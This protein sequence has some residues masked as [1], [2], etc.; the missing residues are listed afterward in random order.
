MSDNDDDDDDN[1]DKGKG[2]G[3]SAADDEAQVKKALAESGMAD[4]LSSELVVL[5]RRFS[6]GSNG[7]DLNDKASK[8]DMESHISDGAGFVVLVIGVN[9]TL[10]CRCRR[11]LALKKRSKRFYQVEVLF[12]DDTS[13]VRIALV[14]NKLTLRSSDNDSVMRPQALLNS[15][16]SSTSN[17]YTAYA[18]G[19]S[20]SSTRPSIILRSA[21]YAHVF[22]EGPAEEQKLQEVHHCL[23]AM[24]GTLTDDL[25]S[26]VLNPGWN[27][28]TGVLSVGPWEFRIAEDVG[29]GAADVTDSEARKSELMALVTR[30]AWDDPASRNDPLGNLGTHGQRA[31]GEHA[32]PGWLARARETAVQAHQVALRKEPLRNKLRKVRSEHQEVGWGVGV[33]VVTG[34]GTKSRSGEE[35]DTSFFASS[36]QSVPAPAP[37]PA[38]TQSS[39]RQRGSSFLTNSRGSSS[40]SSNGSSH[41]STA[42][43]TSSTTEVPFTVG[44]STVVPTP[45]RPPLERAPLF[46][47][48]PDTPI[49]PASV[50]SDGSGSSAPGTPD[51]GS[52]M[53]PGFQ[54]GDG[55]GVLDSIEKEREEEEEEGEEEEDEEEEEGACEKEEEEKEK[56]DEGEGQGEDETAVRVRRPLL[57]RTNQQPLGH[58]ALRPANKQVGTEGGAGTTAQSAQDSPL[59]PPSTANTDVDTPGD[60]SDMSVAR[61]V[62]HGHINDDDN[63]DDDDDDDD[64]D[65][66]N[67][68]DPYFELP[69]KIAQI[70]KNTD[71]VAACQGR[72]QGN[73]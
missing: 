73:K 51:A 69:S 30:S 43:R 21:L 53:D 2:P 60:C 13:D 32:P 58:F 8:K 1:D 68:E 28:T 18:P 29:D 37:A 66:D 23:L 42:P 67:D 72:G 27:V 17:N 11:M 26:L 64:D 59:S 47:P 33:G 49:T 14:G 46:I 61:S 25:P 44:G 19:S 35:N 52:N 7:M 20:G 41:I 50:V 6:Q 34:A 4:A 54:D 10:V 9:R 39:V 40:S 3:Q 57:S 70:L 24:N 45:R 48:G 62:N 63:D 12:D 22:A 15:D 16:M 65:N 38:P 71:S 31:G 56:N 5:A 55:G 36:N